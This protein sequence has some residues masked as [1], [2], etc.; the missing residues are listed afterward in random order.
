MPNSTGSAANTKSTMMQARVI[1]AHL[2]ELQEFHQ[3]ASSILSRID[4]QSRN[5]KRPRL[6]AFASSLDMWA[7]VDTSTFEP[8]V[9]E[10]L[11]KYSSY[12]EEVI[13]LEN[14][15]NNSLEKVKVC[16][17]SKVDK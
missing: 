6:T 16:F 4:H 10:E 3:S 11:E 2:E 1:R 12:K 5:D 17:L 8:V 13:E 14:V 15:I 9:D 7:Q